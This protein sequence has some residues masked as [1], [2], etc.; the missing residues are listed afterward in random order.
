MATHGHRAGHGARRGCIEEEGAAGLASVALL[1]RLFSDFQG[2]QGALILIFCVD[3]AVLRRVF[4]LASP[5]EVAGVDQVAVLAAEDG[6]VEVA[7][8]GVGDDRDR[9]LAGARL[10]GFGFGARAPG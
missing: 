4:D 3:L 10:D 9:G 5:A 1:A 8:R 2:Q 6:E 7:D